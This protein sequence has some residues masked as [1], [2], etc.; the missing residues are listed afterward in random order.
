MPSPLSAF[1]VVEQP[2][3]DTPLCARLAMALAG[4]ILADLGAR[5]I[6]VEPPQG[7]LLRRVPPLL[8]RGPLDERSAV[9]QF[10]AASKRSCVLD[11][12]DPGQ[13]SAIETIVGSA[14]AAIVD[15]LACEVRDTPRVVVAVTPFGRSSARRG[16]PVSE[17]TVMAL[18]GLLDIVGDPNRQPLRLAGHQAAYAAGLAAFSG[19]LAGLALGPSGHETI[20]VSLLDVCQW[21]NWKTLAVTA[22]SARCPTRL[23]RS[24]EW[25]VVQCADGHVAVVF[26]EKDWP[27]L[28]RMIGAP[29]L[30]ERFGTRAARG[31]NVAVV[32]ECLRTWFRARS[33]AEIYREA[34]ALGVPLGPVWTIAELATDP[35]Y[36]ARDFLRS[37]KHPDLGAVVMPRLPV[38]W[39]GHG[40]V[41]R[42][43]PT[44]LSARISA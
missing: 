14:D 38:L 26:L 12:R 21:L 4:R 35:Q 7:D 10:L 5:V 43:A 8:E 16:E 37:L 33:R 32:Y 30:A 44:L 22:D 9:Y 19:L 39:D 13:R 1:T 34:R 27:V 41:P 31:Q 15:G 28:C 23:G 25:Q 24:E 6:V 2:A 3:P 20:D 11:E 29:E 18:G 42:P 40:F 17:F 36:L